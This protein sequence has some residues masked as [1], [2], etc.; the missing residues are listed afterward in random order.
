MLSAQPSQAEMSPQ[1]LDPRW[2]RHVR[3]VIRFPRFRVSERG[4]HHAMS[5]RLTYEQAAAILGC[6]FSNVAKLVRKGDLTSSGKR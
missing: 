5:P 2:L 6:H 4:D 3:G 1:I